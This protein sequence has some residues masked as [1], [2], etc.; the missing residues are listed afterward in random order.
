MKVKVIWEFEVDTEDFDEKHVDIKELAKDLT[1][2]EMVYLL[3]NQE[4][5]AEDF[6]YEV[7]SEDDTNEN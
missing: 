5:S 2:R 7:E 1:R 4:M 6:I 3:Q